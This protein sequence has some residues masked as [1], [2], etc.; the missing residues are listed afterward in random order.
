MKRLLALILALAGLAV[1]GAPL[2]SA[3]D[4]ATK[5]PA[6]TPVLTKIGAT[7]MIELNDGGGGLPYLGSP[8]SYN[9]GDLKA[10]LTNFHDSGVYDT[11]LGQVDALAVKY[12]TNDWHQWKA[13]TAKHAS[14]ARS[15]ARASHNGGGGQGGDHGGKWWNKKLAIVFDVDETALSNYSAIVADGFVY[16]PKSQAEATDEIGVAIKPSLDL[17]NLAKSKG[18]TP[19]FITGRPEA[20]RAPT[21]DNLKREGFADWGQA[22]LKPAGFTGTTVQYK[23][24]ARTQIEQQGYHIVASVGD[25]YSDLAGGHADV[26]FKLPNP[27]YFLP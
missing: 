14:K 1:A 11:E 6:P 3:Q 22:F 15:V 12:I 20:Q 21:E 13:A 7:P 16:G 27:F 19:F 8:T 24:G 17:Y 25:Q 26:A 23:T 9:A 10:A 2:A 5:I 4:D 18:I